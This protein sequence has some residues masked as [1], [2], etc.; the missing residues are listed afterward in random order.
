MNKADLTLEKIDP[1]SL[2]DTSKKRRK[3]L[4]G[5][6]SESKKKD[7]GDF[8][9][10]FTVQDQYNDDLL[11]KK[12]KSTR[13]SQEDFIIDDDDF[14]E[15]FGSEKE[16]EI[17]IEDK[18]IPPGVYHAHFHRP[19]CCCNHTCLQAFRL[20]SILCC[21]PVILISVWMNGIEYFIQYAT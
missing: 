19:R 15:D 1:N 21:M 7:K 12:S 11:T 13:L 20:V 9:V 10:N 16:S 8:I 14:S 18:S 2:I 17:H 4:F 6:V 3:E 5:S